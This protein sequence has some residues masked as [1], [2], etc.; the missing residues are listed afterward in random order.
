[1]T[2]FPGEY[3]EVT[4]ENIV[5]KAR[6]YLIYKPAIGMD[7]GNFQKEGPMM[8]TPCNRP[9]YLLKFET[10]LTLVLIGSPSCNKRWTKASTKGQKS[11]MPQ[12]SKNVTTIGWWHREYSSIR[13][14]ATRD[15][16]LYVQK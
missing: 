3:S 13:P 7:L 9:N 12:S 2:I 10:K 1:M 6:N 8:R 4:N 14:L 16:I 5:Y 11:R 15:M